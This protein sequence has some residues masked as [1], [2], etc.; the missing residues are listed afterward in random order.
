MSARVCTVLCVLLLLL[1]S[2]VTMKPV[3]PARGLRPVAIGDGRGSASTTVDPGLPPEVELQWDGTGS[4]LVRPTINDTDVG[5]FVLDTGASGMLIC[6]EAARKAGLLPLGTTRLQDGSDTTVFLGESFELG[7]LTLGGTKYAGVDFPH[8][9]SVFGT[10]AAG[11]CGFDLFAETIFELDAAAKT[12]RIYD[13]ATY[14]L[15]DEAAWQPL[16]LHI[17]LPHAWCEFEGGHRGL[18]VLDSGYGDA[19]CFFDDTVEQYD[20]LADRKTRGRWVLNF[21]A[22]TRIREGP[23]QW[24]QLGPTRIDDVEK[25]HFATQPMRLYFGPDDVMGLVGMKLMSRVRVVFDYSN[26][27][28]AFVPLTS[29]ASPQE[30]RLRSVI[31]AGATR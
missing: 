16:E 26:N 11:I 7:P 20:L 28:I 19:V 30:S 13:P 24:F 2:C 6:G 17:N 22:S 14:V 8:S 4:L 1:S 21:G 10:K 23:L 29:L 27:R 25:A 18:F 3:K 15:P 5:W 12:I 9:S 31:L